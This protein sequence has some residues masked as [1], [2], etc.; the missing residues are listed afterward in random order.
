MKNRSV[1]SRIRRIFLWTMIGSFCL[2]AAAGIF[3]LIGVSFDETGARVLGTTLTVG[4]FSLAMLCCGAVFN[5]R[6]QLVGVAGVVVCLLT[7]GWSIFL[8]W[9]DGYHEWNV[10][11][12]LLTGITFT[13]AFSFASLVLASATQRDKLVRSLLGSFLVLL[14]AS[15]FL[16]LLLIWDEGWEGELFPR[17]Y[18]IVLILAVLCG[19]V[20]P[21]LSSLRNRGTPHQAAGDRNLPGS[22]LAA[23][24]DGGELDPT[25]VA[26]LQREAS[27]R[28]ITVAQLVDPLLRGPR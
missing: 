6:T 20:A 11:Q 18:G 13:V 27:S 22:T 23:P 2:A 24:M 10:Y 8:I 3:V 16:T 14:I 19:V 28:G 1:G 26:A 25:L 9:S 21:L 5:R 4:L 15:I 17:A 7:L 12:V